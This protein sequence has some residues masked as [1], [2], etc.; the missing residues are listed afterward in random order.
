[1]VF[2]CTDVRDT[3]PPPPPPPRVLPTQATDMFRIILAIGGDY[4]PKRN[5]F[6]RLYNRQSELACEAGTESLS[7]VCMNV[8]F[9]YQPACIR[10][11]T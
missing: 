7:T 10:G 4:F 6:I 1:M 5:L 11:L 8:M 9:L 3:K 2:I